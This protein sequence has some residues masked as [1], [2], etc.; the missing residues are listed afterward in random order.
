MNETRGTVVLSDFLN[1]YETS[2]EREEGD[3][4]LEVVH[5]EQESGGV[6]TE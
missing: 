3:R 4:N 2:V 1:S 5:L 6:F